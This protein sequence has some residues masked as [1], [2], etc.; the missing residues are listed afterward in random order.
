MPGKTIL[1]VCGY[2]SACEF[3]WDDPMDDVASR[4]VTRKDSKGLTH[5]MILNLMLTL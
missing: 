2:Y 3:K 4:H 5:R 1:N